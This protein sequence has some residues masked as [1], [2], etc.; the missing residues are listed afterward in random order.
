MVNGDMDNN[1]ETHN[2]DNRKVGTTGGAIDNY[3]I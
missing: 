3:N 1:N 2:K